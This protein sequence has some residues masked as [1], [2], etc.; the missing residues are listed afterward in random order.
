MWQFLSFSLDRHHNFIFQSFSKYVFCDYFCL[1][2]KLRANITTPFSSSALTAW[3]IKSWI[4][5]YMIYF[6]SYLQAPMGFHHQS[7]S[8]CFCKLS[9]CA[10]KIQV[11]YYRR[12]INSK[13]LNWCV[14]MLKF[15]H[16]YPAGISFL[17]NKNKYLEK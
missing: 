12:Q 5:I 15:D 16:Q 11:K 13:T 3:M 6:F 8:P 14:Q 9:T 1:H 17:L 10:D 4:E 2:L 7:L